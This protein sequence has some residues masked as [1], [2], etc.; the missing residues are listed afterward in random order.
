MWFDTMDGEQEGVL[1][2]A[3]MA[4]LI[5][6]KVPRASTDARKARVEG[7][8]CAKDTASVATGTSKHWR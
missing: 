3:A 5:L 6:W 7:I 8:V 2:N 1:L 4:V